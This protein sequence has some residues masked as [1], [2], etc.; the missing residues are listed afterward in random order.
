MIPET[1]REFAGDEAYMRLALRIA[2]RGLG[3]VEPNP[4]VGCVIVRDAHIIGQ[5]FHRRFGGRHAEINA[6]RACPADVSGATV[7]VT[8]EPCCP[9]EKKTP[10]CVDALLAARVKRVA[11]GAIDPNPQVAGRSVKLLEGAGIAVCVGVCG[12][13]AAD[14]IAPF[15]KWITRKRPWVIAKWAQSVDGRI[16]T[17]TG[18]SK[19]IS[20]ETMRADAHRVR[21]RVDAII[22]GAGTALADDPMLTNRVSQPPRVATRV[23][24]DPTL[25]CAEI[26]LQLRATAR[27]TPTLFYHAPGAAAG[28]LAALQRDGCLTREIAAANTNT[29]LD[30]RAA[31]LD[32]DLIL[33]D[34]AERGCTNVLIEGGAATLGSFF[35]AGAV[36]EVHCYIAPKLIGGREA[37]GPIAGGGV[38]KIMEAAALRG[39]RMRRLGAGWL[40]TG[41]L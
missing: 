24:I 17:R 23:V 30:P 26:A 40:L 37:L 2:R 33:A 18:D 41:R 15:T 11:I 28:A 13:E 35:D 3:R 27:Q 10:P 12:E 16:A 5:G 9:G 21:G 38:S 32:T 34:L 36:D 4:M 8:L 29:L 25:R 19:W 6:M 39:P 22:V 7:F 1:S 31:R 20:D 14:L